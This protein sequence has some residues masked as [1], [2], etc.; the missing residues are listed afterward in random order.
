MEIEIVRKAG[1]QNKRG[2]LQ[3]WIEEGYSIFSSEGPAS[4]QVERVARN[5]K[6]N[7]SGFY[8]I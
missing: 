4:I 8:E 3:S 1:D 5:L 7:K 6:K 2:S